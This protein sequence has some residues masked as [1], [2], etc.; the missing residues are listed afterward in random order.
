MRIS[1]T[2]PSEHDL[3]PQHTFTGSCSLGT[4]ALS[5]P[6]E[7]S[8]RGAG[9]HGAREADLWR[10]ALSMPHRVRESW[11]WTTFAPTPLM[12]NLGNWARKGLTLR[13]LASSHLWLI[14]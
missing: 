3:A 4:Q 9:C 12:K 14:L 1:P 7:T 10:D 13:A 6:L 8:S 2:Q 5:L 11:S